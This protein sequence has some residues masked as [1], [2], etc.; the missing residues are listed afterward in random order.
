MYPDV[1]LGMFLVAQCPQYS[2][3]KRALY[4]DEPRLH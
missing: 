3:L 4:R 1:L 2:N